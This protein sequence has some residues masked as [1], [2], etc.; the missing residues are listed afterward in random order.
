MEKI[1]SKYSR[2]QI[3]ENKFYVPP[4]C[5]EIAFSNQGF[6]GFFVNQNYVAPGQVL[7]FDEMDIR[8]LVKAEFEIVFPLGVSIDNKCIVNFK[9]YEIEK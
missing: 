4:K 3:T 9:N 2:T 8:A 1:F 5:N 6:T 7:E